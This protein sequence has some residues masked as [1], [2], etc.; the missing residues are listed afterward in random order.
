MFWFT[1]PSK[2]LNS[3]AS[4]I[5]TTSSALP[6]ESALLVIIYLGVPFCTS[7]A[8]GTLPTCS[9]TLK[10]ANPP[11]TVFDSVS[12]FFLTSTSTVRRTLSMLLE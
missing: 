9:G 1:N 3:G 11:L 4:K 2:Q 12:N 6:L 8:F 5:S 7:T 10:V